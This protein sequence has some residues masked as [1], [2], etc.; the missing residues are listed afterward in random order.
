MISLLDKLSNKNYSPRI[1][2]IDDK[3]KTSEYK[4]QDREKNS[5]DFSI[6]KIPK[7]REVGQSYFTSLFSTFKTFLFAIKLIFQIRP[8]LVVLSFFYFFYLIIFL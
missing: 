5:K 7:S 1:Y 4:A 8:D 6:L 2:V 3:N